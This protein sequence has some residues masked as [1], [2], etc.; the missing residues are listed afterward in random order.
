MRVYILAF[1]NNDCGESP[2]CLVLL[3]DNQADEIDDHIHEEA[4]GDG[5]GTWCSINDDDVTFNLRGCTE[6]KMTSGPVEVSGSILLV[7]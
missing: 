2:A 3:T 6:V 4:Q 5:D 1:Q 7:S